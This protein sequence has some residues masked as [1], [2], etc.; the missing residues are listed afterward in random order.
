[1]NSDT[2]HSLGARIAVD[3]LELRDMEAIGKT[4]AR[5]VKHLNARDAMHVLGQA[6]GFTAMILDQIREHSPS[7]AAMLTQIRDG[8]TADIV[9]NTLIKGEEDGK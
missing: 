8:L 9:A 2:R 4:V 3:I 5:R 1:M 7:G 6:L